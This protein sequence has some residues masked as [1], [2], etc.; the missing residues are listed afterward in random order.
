MSAA[1]GPRASRRRS[2]RP[3]RPPLTEAMIGRAALD[4]IDASGWESCTMNALAQRLGVRGPS[5][6][7]YIAGQR[8]VIELVRALIVHEIQDPS[9]YEQPWDEAMFQ[10]G[11]RYYRAFAQHPN[12]IQLLITTP[13]RDHDTLI[14]YDD[15]LGAMSADG[16]DVGAAFEAL[17]G[18][19]NLALGFAFEWNAEDLVLDSELAEDHGAATLAEALRER[20][21][22]S[23]AQEETF[24]RLLRRYIAVFGASREDG[25]AARDVGGAR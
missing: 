10:F 3:S 14:M 7:H 2:G 9:V 4:I 5:L 13:V 23:A 25:V 6:Y 24:E 19:E 22:Q 15:F 11:M 18:L 8:E 16:L 12:A 1:A 17:L 20:A 21:S